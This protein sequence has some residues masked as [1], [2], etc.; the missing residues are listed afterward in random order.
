MREGMP[1]EKQLLQ[2]DQAA[3][4]KRLEAGLKRVAE[5]RDILKRLLRILPSSPGAVRIHP[6]A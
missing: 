5:Q 3:R 2:E 4:L 6:D 1:V